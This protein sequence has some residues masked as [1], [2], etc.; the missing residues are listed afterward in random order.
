MCRKSPGPTRT[1]GAGASLLS[2]VGATGGSA[3]V[4]LAGRAGPVAASS[5]RGQRRCSPTA[6][7]KPER[8]GRAGFEVE[9]GRKTVPPP[10]V[11]KDHNH[12]TARAAANKACSAPAPLARATIAAMAAGVVPLSGELSVW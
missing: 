4:G 6:K 10:S 8:E 1:N 11:G 3:R 5:T 2:L 12:H 9:Y 7:E